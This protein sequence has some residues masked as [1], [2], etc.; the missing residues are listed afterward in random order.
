MISADTEE[1]QLEWISALT[2]ATSQIDISKACIHTC[3]YM[4]TVDVIQLML[5]ISASF[6]IHMKL[7]Q[8]IHLDFKLTRLDCSGGLVG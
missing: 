4:Y 3:M 5:C 1:E 7:S 2:Y 8:P 6:Y